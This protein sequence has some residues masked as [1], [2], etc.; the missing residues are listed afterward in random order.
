MK[1]HRPPVQENGAVRKRWTGL[2]P[3]A[4]L[5]PN[6]YRLGMSNLGMQTVYSLA[7]RHPA[8]V[9]ERIFLPDTPS[10]PPRSIESSRLLIDF[11]VLLCS[12]SFEQDYINLIR[13]F[14]TGGIRPRAIEREQEGEIRPGNPL[15][16][17]GGVAT[18]INPEPLAPCV[19]LFLLG[20][21]EVTL[22]LLIEK[23]LAIGADTHYPQRREL[24]ADFA[25]TVPGC[26][27]PSLYT[28]H[29]GEKGRLA[30]IV[31]A[32][33]AIPFPVRRP[34]LIN[35]PVAGHSRLLTPD[36]EFA[37]LFLVEMGRGCSRGCRFCAAGFVYRP[38]RLWTAEA[39]E[40]A[41]AEKPATV[42]RVGLLGMEM[43]RPDDLARLA[44]TLEASSCSLA[45]SSLRA[46]ALGPELLALL[47][48]SG[49]KTAAIAPD[50]GSERLRRVINKGLGEEDVLRA[51]ELL[52]TAGVTNLKL[53]FMVG[54]P[55]ENDEDLAE[56]A[57]FTLRIRERAMAI[58]R[59]RGRLATIIVSLNCFVPKAWTPFQYAAFAG[60]PVLKKKIAYL[61]S[62]FAGQANLRMNSDK[63]D[64]AFLQAVLARGDR[65]VGEMLVALAVSGKNWRQLFRGHGIDPDEYTR[66][67]D[68]GEVFAWEVVDHGIR[69]DYLWAEYRRALAGKTTGPCDTVRCR[70]CG[71]CNGEA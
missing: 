71:V 49:L 32:S 16:I 18:F 38:P 8:V 67:R 63:P 53:Y 31:P 47:Q 48:S 9:C 61:R 70:R 54:L 39:I 19:D 42:E 60:V 40:A 34:T 20:E 50:G 4:L 13:L 30:A 69:R 24:L 59:E 41:L 23:L 27:V 36:A 7:N 12:I 46:D 21:A 33:D 66:A 1:G 55:G 45:F 62:R 35:S 14:V 51:A 56:L 37:D 29:C 17:A 6:V 25:A 68:R 10:A 22:E 52:V 44:V 65:R 3:I 15:V 57:D 2:L 26:Y 64:N 58:G 5:F 28:M 11:P 43:A